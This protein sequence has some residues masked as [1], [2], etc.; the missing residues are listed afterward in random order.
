MKAMAT[1]T[2]CLLSLSQPRC[3]PSARL[4]ANALAAVEAEVIP[5]AIT[6]KVTRK[7]RK[8]MS[9]ARCTNEAAPPARGY[10][11]TISR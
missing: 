5:E 10:L 1:S 7:V 9:K 6:V 4:D 3:S 8:W 2:T 11:V